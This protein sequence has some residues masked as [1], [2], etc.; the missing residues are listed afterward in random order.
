M[1]K[2]IAVLTWFNDMVK[3]K[4]GCISGRRGMEWLQLSAEILSEWHG[5]F[6]FLILLF[7]DKDGIIADTVKGSLMALPY[8]KEMYV[9]TGALRWCRDVYTN[10]D[11]A[12]AGWCIDFPA[13]IVKR[14]QKL[15]N[16][17]N[18]LMSGSAFLYYG[19]ELGMSSGKMKIS[20][21]RCTGR[22][23]D[24]VLRVCDGWPKDKDDIIKMKYGSLEG[25]GENDG[26]SFIT[27]WNE[28]TESHWNSIRWSPEKGRIWW[29]DFGWYGMRDPENLWWGQLTLV[30]N[31]SEKTQTV[32][33]EISS[34][35][36]E[37]RKYP[38]QIAG[39][40]SIVA[41]TEGCRSG[42]KNN[43]IPAYSVVILE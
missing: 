30:F 4:R 32:D 2:I 7:A 31:N 28:G 22:R 10:H 8:G 42:W 6:C 24:A 20:V 13:I 39:G 41:G 35:T 43:T 26:N 36:T 40:A 3:S 29:G 33:L 37:D 16:A 19:E 9:N 14:R 25:A 1:K 12:Q 15:E 38:L 17:M 23:M 5:R 34:Q 27:L 11:M 18:L 21:L